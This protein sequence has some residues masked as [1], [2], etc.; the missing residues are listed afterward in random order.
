MK[1]GGEETEVGSSRDRK[2]EGRKEGR[3]LE[4]WMTAEKRRS[5]FEF[6]V[7][8]RRIIEGNYGDR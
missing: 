3:S 5:L 8:R 6:L 1:G 7:A 4:D 2:T